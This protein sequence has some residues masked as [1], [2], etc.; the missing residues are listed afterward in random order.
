MDVVVHW[1]RHMGIFDM[2]WHGHM[3]MHVAHGCGTYTQCAAP[4]CPQHAYAA[5]TL[6][7]YDKASRA[8]SSGRAGT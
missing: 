2:H 8:G 7:Y 4:Y 3:S 5:P 6:N 1:H